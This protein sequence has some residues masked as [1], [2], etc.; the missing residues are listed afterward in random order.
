MTIRVS[1]LRMQFSNNLKFYAKIFST[2]VILYSRFISSFLDWKKKNYRKFKIQLK[3]RLK[4]CSISSTLCNLYMKLIRTFLIIT[5]VI[6]RYI[7]NLLLFPLP[8]F[9]NCL[10][11]ETRSMEYVRNTDSTNANALRYINEFFD[12]IINIFTR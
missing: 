7:Y 1:S 3:I 6:Q 12:K 8:D 9:N 4:H 5:L 11:D 10:S 2:Y